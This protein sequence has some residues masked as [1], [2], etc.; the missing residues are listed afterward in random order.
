MPQE[1]ILRDAQQ[2]I[3]RNDIKTVRNLLASV[4]EVPDANTVSAILKEAARYGRWEIVREICQ[5]VSNNKPDQSAVD[6]AIEQASLTNRLEE[7]QFICDQSTTKPSQQVI[8]AI[9]QR[10]CSSS[11]PKWNSIDYLCFLN[12]ENKPTQPFIAQAFQSAAYYGKW[13]LVKK[14]C[15][16]K[17]NN[18]PSQE[19]IEQALSMAFSANKLEEFQFICAQSETKPSQQAIAT[20]LDRACSTST[21]RWGFIDYLCSLDSQNKPPQPNIDNAIKVAAYYGQWDLVKKICSM[22]GS[23]KPSQPAIDY[24]LEAACSANRLKEF[25]FICAQSVTIPSQSTIEAILKKA[26]SSPS[27]KWD[28]IDCLCFLNSEN[29]PRQPAIDDALAKAAYYGQWKLVRKIC[30]MT[31]DHK[32]SEIA[33]DYALEAACSANKLEELQFICA[34]SVTKP[35]QKVI[36]ILLEK[37]SSSPSS[38]WDFIDYLCGLESENKSRTPTIDYALKMAAYYG[39]WKLVKKM[40][41]MKGDNKPSQ[42]AIEYALTMAFSANKFEEFQFICGQSVTKPSQQAIETLLQKGCSSPSSKWD[43]IDHLCFLNSANKPGQSIIDQV[44]HAA[45]YYDK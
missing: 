1:Q 8:E 16:M 33:V 2:A 41:L 25:Q 24:A 6:Y 20:L 45:A 7:M 26:C 3:Q 22:T 34:Q 11:N 27:S 21:P 5:M 40:C 19:A 18:K 35:S 29:K 36:E 31:G 32:P 39:Q 14:I 4:V 37:T 13:E 30:L 12:S 42:E 10:E 23:N 38:K 9:L 28:F 15:A 44:F 17:S 43:F